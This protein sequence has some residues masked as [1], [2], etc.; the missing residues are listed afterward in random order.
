TRAILQGSP[1]DVYNHGEMKRD[2]TF[3]DDIVKS[4]VK[5]IFLPPVPGC[6]S[7]AHFDISSPSQANCD[8]SS[9]SHPP[10]GIYNIGN[11]EP[12]ELNIFIETLENLLGR[13]AVKNS[14][15]MQPGDVPATYADIEPLTLKTGFRPGTSIQEGLGAFV[16]WYRKYYG[17]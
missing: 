1:I 16:S 11:S 12:V 3:I 9:P 2:F 4:M 8:I 13:K 10:Y 17:Q 14:L 15:P 5:L 6:P 7:R